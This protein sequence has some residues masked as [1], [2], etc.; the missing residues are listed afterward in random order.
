MIDP[1]HPVG[2][3]DK[4]GVADIILESALSTICDFEDSVA[5]VDAEDK[6]LGYS[7]WLGLMQGDLSETFMKGGE[8]MTRTL[9]PDM[10][11]F[12]LH[13]ACADSDSLHAP[14]LHSVCAV[15]LVDA[16]V[17]CCPA[18]VSCCPAHSMH[19]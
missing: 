12:P 5:A 11:V 1:D 15:V 13:F 4:A 14:S 6:V 3:T 9:N 18:S 7:N 16:S 19:P 17:Y 2:K 8:D 10:A